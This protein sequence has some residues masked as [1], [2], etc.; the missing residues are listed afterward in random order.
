MKKELP[1]ICFFGCG[2]IAE[3]HAKMLRGLYPKIDLRFASRDGGKAAE[4]ASLLGG[5][6]SY[7]SYGEAA[8]S[9][10]FD[11]A[12]ITTPHAH[13][14]E[15]AALCA[16]NGRDL[17]IEKPVTRNLEELA[18]IEKAVKASGVR[19]TVAEN[20]L[21]KP[22]L[23]TVRSHI[24]KGH[25]GIPLFLELNKTNRDAISGWRTDAKLMGGGALLEGGVHWVNAMV[26]LAG[27][28]PV[29]VIAFTPGAKYDT[30]VPFEDSIMVV[31]RFKNGVVGKLLHSWRIPN[32][33]RGV[34]L[35]KIYGTEGT[36]SFESNGLYV[37]LNGRRKKRSFVSPLKFL[38]FRAM[39]RAFIEAWV[40]GEPWEPSMGRIRTELS[41]ITAA[42]RSLKTKKI[43]KIG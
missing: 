5:A 33:F 26:S 29:D 36:V 39:H 2:A 17:I 38:G 9:R 41:L 10:A 25:I 14:A 16:K 7:A 37:R 20:Y 31:V 21:Y 18:R 28:D 19:C 23:Q 34:G 12:F 43:E 27:A 6:G 22:F 11:I 3:R 40:S 4:F 32:P 13:H 1:R 35:S 42:Y 24:E 15:I 8:G 30:E